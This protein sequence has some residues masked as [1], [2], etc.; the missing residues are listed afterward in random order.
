[1]AN[2]SIL[3]TNVIVHFI[4][5]DNK[6]QKKQAIEWF[7]QST[8]GEREIIVKPAVVAEAVYV[9]E[10]FYM[11]AR[12]DIAS[13][14]LPFLAMPVLD[15]EDR[16]PLLKLWNDYLSGH[17]FIDSYLAACSRIEKSELLTFDKGLLSLI[18]SG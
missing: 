13:V 16:M 7:R 4:L 1:M 5:G 18:K 17:H 15:V 10:S 3:D 9:L 12:E 8:V 6:S 11:Q 14:M 2:K